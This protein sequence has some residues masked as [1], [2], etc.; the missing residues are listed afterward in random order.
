[1][2]GFTGRQKRIPVPARGV[3]LVGA[4]VAPRSGDGGG[5]AAGCVAALA[6]TASHCDPGPEVLKD[7]LQLLVLGRDG[8]LAGEDAEVIGAL[9]VE[10]LGAVS[11]EGEGPALSAAWWAV[12]SGAADAAL[13]ACWDADQLRCALLAETE[14]AHTVQRAPAGLLVAG[15]S[16]PADPTAALRWA[17]RQVRGMGDI[18]DPAAQIVRSCIHDGGLGLEGELASSERYTRDEPLLA[19]L[20]WAHADLRGAGAGA[21]AQLCVQ[22]ERA[23]LAVT[24][25]LLRTR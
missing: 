13:L 8:A 5:L 11:V 12:A 17:L 18:H 7:Y 2:I 21:G 24:A 15:G 6:D 4:G 14:A 22:V 16:G 9:D 25:A 1:M 20:T 10:P 3:Y 19:M 23:G